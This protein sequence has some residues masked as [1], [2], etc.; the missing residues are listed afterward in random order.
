[1]IAAVFEA[2]KE[3]PAIFRTESHFSHADPKGG[4][5]RSQLPVQ[6][7]QHVLP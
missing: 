6:E 7:V 3:I 4:I 5:V 2:K 1:M